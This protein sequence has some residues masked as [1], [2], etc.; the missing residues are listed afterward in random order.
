MLY[1]VELRAQNQNLA[2][3]TYENTVQ[4]LQRRV[5]SYQKNFVAKTVA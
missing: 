4:M 3:F 2:D 5:F 1:P